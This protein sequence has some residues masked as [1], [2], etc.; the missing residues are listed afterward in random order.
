M[1]GWVKGN[2]GG[3]QGKRVYKIFEF[4]SYLNSFWL[5]YFFSTAEIQ[6]SPCRSYF[7]RYFIKE[8]K[9]EGI[10]KKDG[11]GGG[12][13][14]ERWKNKRCRQRKRLRVCL[15][16]SVRCALMTSGPPAGC[17]ATLER[18][19]PALLLPSV[20]IVRQKVVFYIIQL[21]LL[22]GSSRLFFSFFSLFFFVV[23]CTFFWPVCVQMLNGD[24]LGCLP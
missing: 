17:S 22:V 9:V 5:F 16:R 4:I 13:V 14:G 20:L 24:S 21:N 15:E 8:Y 7:L 10:L 11:R 1:K 19:T 6:P 18:I 23:F 3:R 2:R 12:G